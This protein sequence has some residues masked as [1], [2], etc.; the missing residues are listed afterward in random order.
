MIAD[1]YMEKALKPL[2]VYLHQVF[3]KQGLFLLTRWSLFQMKIIQSRFF[4]HDLHK[5]TNGK[6]A[7]V[8]S[9]RST[10]ISTLWITFRTVWGK[11]SL[12]FNHALVLQFVIYC[13]SFDSVIFL[14][15]SYAWRPYKHWMNEWMNELMNEWMF[16]ASVVNNFNIWEF[17]CK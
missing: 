9:R 2:C 5:L 8:S 7:D 4:S 10:K 15:F 13:L 14:S 3:P 12:I 1:Y 16:A 6:Q 17:S 11:L